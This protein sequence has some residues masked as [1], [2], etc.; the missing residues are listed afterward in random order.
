MHSAAHFVHRALAGAAVLTL[1]AACGTQTSTTSTWSA[2]VPASGPLK[3]I[4]VVGAGVKEGNRR[5]LEDQLSA[6]LGQTGVKATPSYQLFPNATPSKEEARASVQQGGHD[7][8]LVSRLK[9]IKESQQFYPG[10]YD[11]GFWDGY[12]GTGGG[13]YGGQVVTDENV[14]FE[15]T[16]WDARGDG[17]LL[18]SANTSTLNP[19]SSN[20]FAEAL[21]K[22]IVPELSKS[23]FVPPAKK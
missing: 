7:G 20:D 14:N 3:S 22:T 19:T 6:R 1:A 17:K 8:I 16:L 5:I 15:N 2:P 11:G 18:W 21:S 9:N 10:G 12:Y 23:G 13:W 4:V